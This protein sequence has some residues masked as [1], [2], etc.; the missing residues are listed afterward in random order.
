MI[1][2]SAHPGSPHR[3]AAASQRSQSPLHLIRASLRSPRVRLAAQ[4]ALLIL[5]L[6]PIGRQAAQDWPAVSLLARQVK[7]SALLASVGALILGSLFLP[8]AMAAFTR[9][10]PRRINYRASA[11]AY[12]G[13]QPMKY[14]PGSFW[15]LPGRV[16]LLQ[17]LGHEASLASAALL[18]EMTTQTFSAALV[19]VG[20]LEW[21]DFTSVWYRG[22]AWLILAGSSAVSLLL[23]IAPALA[24]RQLVR[25]TP[26]GRA[27]AQVAEIPLPTRLANLLLATL[28]YAVM[29]LLMGV[30]FYALVVAAD[31]R[32]DVALLPVAIAIFAL[33]WLAGFLTPISPGGIGVRESAIV[34]LLTPFVGGPQAVAVA[35]LSRMLAL[36]VELA[37]CAGAWLPWRKSFHTLHQPARQ[38]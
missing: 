22:V 27:L 13:S 35:L 33:A 18:F 19:G 7:A 5:C 36:A 9:S 16:M 11:L 10:A 3:S 6:L 32:L 15:I 14:L 26:I 21:R 25:P 31:P 28:L 12:F 38:P 24:R 29:W 20:L 34:L 30:S 1:R 23:V 8:T 17:G 4:V 37:F 2:T